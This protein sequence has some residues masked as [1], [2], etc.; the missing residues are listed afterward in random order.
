MYRRTAAPTELTPLH[1]AIARALKVDARRPERERRTARML[2]EE[3]KAAGYE[4]VQPTDGLLPRVA[5]G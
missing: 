1:E 2:H 3:L 4:G 5:P